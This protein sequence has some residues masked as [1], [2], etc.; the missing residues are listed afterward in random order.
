MRLLDPRLL[1]H[2]RAARPLLALDTALGVGVALLVILQA[3]LLATIVT[4]AFYGASL[5]A[6]WPE[7]VWLALAF[8]ARGAL[9]W[10]FEVAGVKAAAGVLSE[11]RDWHW[12][13]DGC[14]TNRPR[15]IGP[16]AQSWRPSQCRASTGS[17]RTS[18]AI[19]RRSYWP[20][21][22]RSPCS[23]EPARSTS[24]RGS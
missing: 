20:A 3:T 7:I 18:A 11:L 14:A 5:A 23:A 1:R 4:R 6:I 19:S 15:S 2:A 21:W 10:G 24:S 22:F 8:A 13:N 12:W 16:R 17:R 9:S